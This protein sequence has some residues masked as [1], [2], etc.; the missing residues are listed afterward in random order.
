[1]AKSARRASSPAGYRPA[2]QNGGTGEPSAGKAVPAIRSKL[3]L[4]GGTPFV[5]R[6]AL[7]PPR[8]NRGGELGWGM[9][10]Y[11]CAEG[12]EEEDAATAGSS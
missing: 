3:G 12:P 2:D 7:Q 4:M 8:S 6:S 10:S 1:M 11:R 9:G 5:A